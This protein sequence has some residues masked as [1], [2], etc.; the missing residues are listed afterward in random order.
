MNISWLF[1]IETNRWS[2]KAVTFGAVDYTA[3][4]LPDSFDGISMRWDAQSQG[5]ITP[6]ELDFEIANA[7]GLISKALL[8]DKYCTIILVTDN[9]ECRRWKFKIKSVTEAYGA[10][11]LYCV[12]ILQ[13]HLLGS[14][15]NTAHPREVFPSEMHE[16]DE[17]DTYRI[18]VI[19][20]KAYIPLMFVSRWDVDEKGY[21]VL[22]KDNDYDIFEVKDPPSKGKYIY[23]NIDVDPEGYVFNQHTD[24]GIKLSEFLVFPKTEIIDGVSTIIEGEYDPV[25]W[26]S[27]QQPLVQFKKTGDSDSWS[28][29]DVLKSL[30]L[31]FGVSADDIDTA[32]WWDAEVV[33]AAQGISWQ[34]GFYQSEMRETIINSLLSQCDAN[35]YISDKIEILPFSKTSVETFDKSK[36][37][38]LSFQSSKTTS[39]NI[40]SGRVHWC[41]ADCPQSELS[42]KALLS[43]SPSGTTDNPDGSI[44]EAPFISNSIAAQKLGILHFQRKIV[45]E[46]ISFSTAGPKMSSLSTLKPGQVVTVNDPLF[47]GSQDIIV[48]DLEIKRDA[49][50]NISGVRLET[51][52][53]FADLSATDIVIPTDNTTPT[54]VTSDALD[55]L[56]SAAVTLFKRES[57]KTTN[58]LSTS[59]PDAAIGVNE[60]VTIYGSSGGNNIS[61]ARGSK[62]ECVNFTGVNTIT[63]NSNFVNVDP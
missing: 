55:G 52:N 8:E 13:D 18:P 22:G 2:T 50:V 30:L 34:G 16:V 58:I 51:L 21:Y 41:K 23:K 63:I 1:Q 6:S 31:S 44:F 62:V 49:Q 54:I 47:G 59:I 48:T 11:R 33:F 36:T 42:G 20:G 24:T 57:V 45:K 26:G 28:P 10:I 37:K 7:D 15:P 19:F 4:V 60:T 12:D 53:E 29:A 25:M 38:K 39:P 40:D 35:F 9:S 32:N 14:F 43:V 5:L 56:N 61:V 27:D 17:D 46:S 3:S